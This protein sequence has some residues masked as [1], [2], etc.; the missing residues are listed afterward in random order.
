MRG[1]NS[2]EIIDG[3]TNTRG[4]KLAEDIAGDVRV[5]ETALCGF[6]DQVARPCAGRLG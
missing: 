6:D 5:G 1:S 4:A 2:A 3:S